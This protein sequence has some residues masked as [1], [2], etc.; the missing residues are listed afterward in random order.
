MVTD[1]IAEAQAAL[2]RAMERAAAKEQ[3]LADLRA[4]AAA[5][6]AKAEARIE[7]D[8]ARIEAAAAGSQE[9]VRKA[10]QA[11]GEAAARLDRAQQRA[12]ETREIARK[13]EDRWFGARD[14]HEAAEAAY[15]AACEQA[16]ALKQAVGE[17]E[18]AKA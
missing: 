15:L 16:Q 3:R 17:I 10:K 9:K 18:A 8:R 14:A 5:R 4:R 1:R 6:A 12:S 2:D 7:K 11:L 13:A